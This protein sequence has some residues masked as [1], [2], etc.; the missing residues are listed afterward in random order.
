[1]FISSTDRTLSLSLESVKPASCQTHA[2]NEHTIIYLEEA[3]HNHWHVHASLHLKTFLDDGWMITTLHQQLKDPAYTLDSLGTPP[4]PSSLTSTILL[5]PDDVL[6]NFTLDK[7]H[8]QIVR[9]IIA[10]DQSVI[11]FRQSALLNA[12]NFAA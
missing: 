11:A 9:F 6:P 12:Q 5:A 10:N 7:M 4:S 3:E 1:M 8:K 2:F